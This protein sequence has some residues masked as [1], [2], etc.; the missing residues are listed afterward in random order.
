MLK[1]IMNNAKTKFKELEKTKKNYLLL[2]LN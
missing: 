2:K 1:V